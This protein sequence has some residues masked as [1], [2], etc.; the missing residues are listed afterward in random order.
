MLHQSNSLACLPHLL[1]IVVGLDWDGFDCWA[2][3]LRISSCF[4][5][6]IHFLDS[7]NRLLSYHL[8][9]STLAEATYY[10]FHSSKRTRMY[11]SLSLHWFMKTCFGLFF[12]YCLKVCCIPF[13]TNNFDSKNIKEKSFVLLTTIY[14]FHACRG[15]RYQPYWWIFPHK[16]WTFPFFTI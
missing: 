14:T 8:F 6:R 5:N 2:E 1:M 7:S 16:L 3:N 10:L 9:N 4:R 15:Q 12:L 13:Y 11:Q